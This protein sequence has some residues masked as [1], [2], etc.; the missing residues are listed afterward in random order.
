MKS[1]ETS[2]ILAQNLTKVFGSQIAV[3]D[4]SFEVEPGRV[5]GFLGPNGAG[6]TTTLRMIL[7][8][9]RPTAGDARVHGYRYPDLE[10]P[11]RTVGALLDA[12]HIHPLRTGRNHLRVQ[13]A[14][15]DVADRRVDEVLELVDLSSAADKKVG[16]YSLG[17]RQRLGLAAALLGDPRV[18]I[19][20]EPANGLDPSGIR[21]LRGFLRGFAAEDGRAVFV[22]S[23][24]LDEISHIA[25]EV[26]VINKGRLVAHAPVH[27]LTAQAAAR[28][29]IRTPDIQ[30]LFD[31]LVVEDIQVQRGTDGELIAAASGEQVGII[32]VRAGIPI[33]GLCPEDTTLEDIFFQL[34][35]GSEEGSR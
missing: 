15:G 5:T 26:V 34:T 18:L 16:H 31:L 12:S 6:K 1:R 10:A 19:L 23:H 3:D 20:D 29:R 7:G 30:K 27:D 32:A 22:S 33:F 11:S 14:A 13:T 8:L 25:D 2:A 21:W 17:M 35:E 9:A 28:V 4:L 24:L